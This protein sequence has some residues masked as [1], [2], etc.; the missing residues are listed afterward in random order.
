ML[1]ETKAIVHKLGN[2]PSGQ[3]SATS[4]VCRRIVLKCAPSKSFYYFNLDKENFPLK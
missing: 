3:H 2:T 4:S 1:C